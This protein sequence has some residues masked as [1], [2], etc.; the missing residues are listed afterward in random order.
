VTPH[1]Y[2]EADLATKERALGC[3]TSRAGRQ[4]PVLP[5]SRPPDRLLEDAVIMKM[6]QLCRNTAALHST[7]MD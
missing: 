1:Q 3:Q 7:A 6:P 5:E 2:V 4:D